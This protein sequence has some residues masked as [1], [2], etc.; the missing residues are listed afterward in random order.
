M[1]TISVSRA[2]R[3]SHRKARD[4]AEKIARDLKQRF[5]LDYAWD[6]DDM[7]FTRPGVN[8]RMRLDKA[9]V[10]LDVK[11]G[12]LLTPM[13]P[14]IEREIHARLDELFGTSGKA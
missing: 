2:H 9:R 11:L 10:A 5:Q 12:L 7:T 4:A 13:K 8:G 1:P 6:G 3:L 14:L